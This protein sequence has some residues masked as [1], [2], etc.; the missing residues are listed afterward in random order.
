MNV[1]VFPG[2]ACLA[3]WPSVAFL[4]TSEERRRQSGEPGRNGQPA[5]CNCWAAL[6]VWGTPGPDPVRV[7]LL[8]WV[9]LLPHGRQPPRLLCPCDSPGMNTGAG[10]HGLLQ[11][12][13]PIQGLNPHLLCLLLWQAGSSPL[14]HGLPG[15]NSERDPPSTTLPP[16][17]SWAEL[18]PHW[19]LVHR[20][21]LCLRRLLLWPSYYTLLQ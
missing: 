17:P 18:S 10:S 14:C 15:V 8:S 1:I 3:T 12:T 19:E 7:Y 9:W 21:V 5:L 13:L 6:R 4:G 16:S 2:P 20:W 11:A